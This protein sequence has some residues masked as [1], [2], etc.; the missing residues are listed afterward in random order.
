MKKADTTMFWELWQSKLVKDARK[1]IIAPV[2]PGNHAIL[3]TITVWKVKINL[4]HANCAKQEDMEAKC[5]EI[6]CAEAVMQ[7]FLMI[8][9]VW[10][11]Q[12][13]VLLVVKINTQI[14]AAKGVLDAHSYGR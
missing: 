5:W 7:V 1:A 10:S 3:G 13:T 11:L 8:G 4:E 6:L 2:V 14:Q 9:K 12:T